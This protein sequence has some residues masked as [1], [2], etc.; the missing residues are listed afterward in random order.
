[1]DK[2]LKR[3]LILFY[4][5]RSLFIPFFWLAILYIYLTETKGLSPA[6]TMF[7]LSLQEFLL[8]F[9]EVPTGVIADKISRR[10]SVALGYILTSLPFLIIPFTDSY[11][12]FIAIFSIKAIG[13]ALTS[14]ADNSLLYDLLADYD[15]TSL[16]KK[17]LNKSKS[18]MMLVTAICIFIGGFLAEINIELTLILPFPLM[19]IGAIS[20]ILMDEPE[21]SRKAKEI[22]QQNYLKHTSEAFRNILGNRQLLT[23]A[24]IWSI[25]MGLIVNLKW[26]YTP[27]FQALEL[28]L[29]IIG[30]LTTG[31]YLLRSVLAFISVRLMQIDNLKS[32][33]LYSIILSISFIFPILIYNPIIVI[34]TLITITLFSETLMAISEEEIQLKIESKNRSTAMSGIN[35]ISSVVATIMLNGF[36]ILNNDYGIKI[37]LLFLVLLLSV[38]IFLSIYYRK[39]KLSRI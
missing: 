4:I 15:S 33:P 2:R 32:L 18:L 38:N 17:I 1:M 30:G 21:T 28:N 20:V 24:L 10:V 14:G 36:G 6:S 3:N 35:L 11:L 27:I 26:I 12:I 16:Y 9:L 29:V 37:S 39:L 7:L 23:L 8:I 19:I 22:Q 25:V 5:T 34:L 13:K 31:L